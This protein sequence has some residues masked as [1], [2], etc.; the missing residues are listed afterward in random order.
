MPDRSINSKKSNL[1]KKDKI[2]RNIPELTFD[3]SLPIT[4]KK[5]QIIDAI[6]K[7]RVV[8]ISGETG[9]GKTTQI[10]KFCIAAGRGVYG[11]IGCTQPRRIAA[12]TVATRIASETGSDIGGLVGYKIRF[13]NKTSKTTLIKIMTDGVLLAETISDRFL[14]EYD[15]IIVDEAHERSLNIDF[16][17]GFLKSLLF[18]K[19]NLKII[20]TSA[21]IDTEK[22]SRAF[23][24]APVIEVSGRMFPVDV[25]YFTEKISDE[26]EDEPGHV[27]L[28]VRVVDDLQ[29]KTDYGDILIFMPTEQAIRETCEI[30]EGRLYK[31][32]GIFPLF[33]RM[34]AHEQS[35]IFRPFKNRKIIVATNVAETSLTIPG[36][37]YV[38]DT[39]LARIS[40][41]S[42]RLRITSLPVV[43]IS[44]SSADQRKGRCGRIENGI[45]IRLFSEED[46]N[47]RPLYTLPEILRANLAEVILRM[48]AL[49]LGDISDFPFIDLPLPKSIKDGINLLLELEGI[50]LK[51]KT[52]KKEKKGQLNRY[53]LT[54]IGKLMAKMPVDPRLAKMLITADKSGCI[55]E[56]A[57]IASALSIQDPRER[58]AQKTK[59]ADLCH[60]KFKVPS[61]DFI[62]LLN[63]WNIY[64]KTW[65]KVKT[66]NQMRKFCKKEY[67]SFQR[68][69]EWRDIHNQLLSILKEQSKEGRGDDFSRTSDK[70]GHK[71]KSSVQYSHPLYPEIH[72][73]I[74]SGFLSNIAVKKEKNI[75][76]AAK[77]KKVMIFPGSV[78]FNESGKW[79]IASEIIETSRL[80][81]MRAAN[82]EGAWIEE[83]GKD[84]CKYT[85]QH[86]HWEQNRGEVVAHEQVSLFGLLIE[87][88]RSV[89]Y[90]KIDSKEAREIFIRDAL[91]QMDV[92]ELFPFMK[93]NKKLI[94]EIEGLENKLRKRDIFA[95]E[96]EV[97]SFYDK[98]LDNVYDIRTLTKLIRKKRGDKFLCME[99]ED[100]IRYHP[101]KEELSLFP[102]K[103]SIGKNRFKCTYN[104][105]PGKSDDGLTINIPSSLSRNIFSDSIDWLVPGLYKEKITALIKLLPKK[106]RKL[107]VPVHTTVDIIIKEMPK[108][109][110]SIL[111]ELGKFLYERFGVDI[112]VSA[113]PEK[114]LPEHLKARIAILDQHG[115]VIRAGKDKAL[116]LNKIPKKKGAAD[117]LIYLPEKEKIEKRELTS[118]NFGDIDEPIILNGEKNTKIIF[119]QGLEKKTEN[120]KTV[121]L[122]LFQDREAAINSHKE[123]V[124]ALALI[125]ISKDLKFLKKELIIPKDMKKKGDYFGGCKKI[126]NMLY[127]KVLSDLFF[128]NIRKEAEF[129][130]LIKSASSILFEKSRILLKNSLIIINLFYQARESFFEIE[131]KHA[132]KNAVKNFINDLRLQLKR[133]LPEDF[134]DLYSINRLSQITRYVKT[135]ELR[136][137]RGVI[138][139]EKDRIKMLKVKV[140]TKMLDNL[141]S[142]LSPVTSKEKRGVIEELFWIIEE[143]KV[144][145]FAQELK[146][147]FPVSEKRIQKKVN[148]I[149]RMA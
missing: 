67:L 128:K 114:Q 44:K 123:G 70:N 68:M 77:E 21:T 56:V 28:A 55:N 24:D 16:I 146:T 47:A 43:P 9:S 79:I 91:V 48:M 103:V 108:Y 143:Y 117:S 66:E 19:K 126:E 118:W 115:E 105:N 73:A 80:Y 130:N 69:R 101:G 139:L 78:L 7:N 137:K 119:Y 96:E 84:L 94:E 76:K 86:P 85:Y 40:R 120:P 13:Q 49:K 26:E 4:A 51:Q 138:D 36:V 42:P 81:A 111:T 89:S 60:K 30:I 88:K 64:H 35:K 82:I 97:F 15:T 22:F 109:E 41:Y 8:I 106:Y 124:L 83:V 116:L 107:L 145:V 148:E 17:L 11:K 31:K 3:S 141:L 34:P 58:P 110:T 5:D 39:G 38:I 133:L 113:W 134:L 90:G 45:C 98:K 23:D 104:L 32:V 20:I 131:K 136:A 50:A 95:G 112:P 147:P 129:N 62:T 92:K 46:F 29:R 54:K 14:S 27:E 74:L 140:C 72:K 102:D 71:N 52:G 59:E 53:Y 135:L 132:D 125:C 33:A 99:K 61:S 144:S 18:K 65:K 2:I 122:R 1:K 25:Q 75:F 63:I 100:L 121:N 10:P 12:I 87:S 93:H 127:N 37:K 6:I 57:I 149:E 142:D